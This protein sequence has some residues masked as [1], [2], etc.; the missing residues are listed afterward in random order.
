M[1]QIIDLLQ[2][3]IEKGIK[4][5]EIYL[6]DLPADRGSV[7]SNYRP[8][9][10]LQNNVGNRFS[11]TTLIAPLSRQNKPLPTH[12]HLKEGTAG[13]LYDSFVLC[14]QIQTIDKA[15]LTKFIGKIDFATEEFRNIEK[16]VLISLGF[17]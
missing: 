9:I 6:C 8:V 2:S 16:S 4:R 12:V 17:Y 10:I 3:G 5:G 1:A 14:E 15:C 11:T 13:L 7:Q